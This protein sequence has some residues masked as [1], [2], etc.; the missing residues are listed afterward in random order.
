MNYRTRN[1]LS[2]FALIGGTAALAS[3]TFVSTLL[4]DPAPDLTAAAVEQ[5][6]RAQGPSG[7]KIDLVPE[8]TIAASDSDIASNRAAHFSDRREA[9]LRLIADSP[10]DALA[11]LRRILQADE[12]DVELK[13]FAAR[14]L[15]RLDSDEARQ[16]A[17]ETAWSGEPQVARAAVRGIA[18]QDNPASAA[19]LSQL[20]LD[21]NATDS[22][23]IEAATRLAEMRT[24][25]AFAALLQATYADLDRDPGEPV[26]HGVLTAMTRNHPNRIGNFVD[27][28]VNHPST[29]DQTRSTALDA[30]AGGSGPQSL[31]LLLEKAAAGDPEVRDAA[32]WA[33]IDHSD[34][35]LAGPYL[36]ELAARE[37]T[38]WVRAGLYEAIRQQDVVDVAP[39]WDLVLSE[40]DINARLRGMKLL[41]SHIPPGSVTR[42]E[43]EVVPQLQTIARED[44]SVTNRLNAIN[45]L[46][47]AKNSPTAAKALRDLQQTAIDPQT[48]RAAEIALK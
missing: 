17:A 3:V 11:S 19:T 30:M 46:G 14:A 6:A 43:A 42:F 38:P 5:S 22:V 13:A 47:L 39:Y 29:P 35:K 41:A 12:E 4:R 27:Q 40:K 9:L 31:A 25:E 44:R 15:A 34:L 48:Q 37:E 1:T 7:V 32:I 36:T 24:P 8:G 2:T 21:Q 23:R 45:A 33:M 20:L 16:L 10:V 28:L 26:F 18:E